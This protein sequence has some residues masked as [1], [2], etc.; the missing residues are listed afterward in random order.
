[1]K[2]IIAV[3]AALAVSS[4]SAFALDIT[5]GARGN[6]NMGLGTSPEGVM[7]DLVEYQKENF[8]S[9][10]TFKEGGNLG[11]G[12]GVYAN[13][14]LVE[15][16]GG[17]LGVQP[18]LNMNFNNGYNF[19]GEASEL[20]LETKMGYDLYDTTLDIPVLVTFT[21]PVLDALSIGGGI[22]PYLSIPFGADGKMTDYYAYGG[23]VYTDDESKLSDDDKITADMNFGLAFDVNGAY[24]VGPGS[25][26][27]D[28]RYM[29]DFTPTKYNID[30]E[31]EKVFTRRMLTIGA[32]YQIKF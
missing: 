13:F 2:K 10:G 9:V 17:S 11:G 12:F 3:A 5:V 24:K 30:D 32:G 15:L 31:S 21:Y 25:I 28:V 29:L 27:L 20:G 22:G 23:T 26:V 6:F 19:K 1:M 16:G 4:L 18:E 7:K 14:G 8:E